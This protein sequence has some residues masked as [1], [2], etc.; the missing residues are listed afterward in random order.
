MLAS[1]RH[2]QSWPGPLLAVLLLLAAPSAG[3][4]DFGAAAQQDYRM[5]LHSLERTVKAQAGRE[6]P[7]PPALYPFGTRPPAGEESQVWRHL[8]I[9]RALGRLEGDREALERVRGGT[10]FQ[11]VSLARS[12]WNLSEYDSSLVWY[13]RAARRDTTAA[14]HEDI[15]RESLAAAIALGDSLLITQMLLNTIGTSRL[16]GRE[17]ELALAY[18][19][20]LAERNTHELELLVSK[21]A[22]NEDRMGPRLR[23][24]HAFA[25]TSLGRWDRALDQLQRLLAGGGLSHGLG[26]LQR[27]WV[28][29]TVPDL[30]FLLGRGA[31][32]RPLY[33]QLTESELPELQGWAAYQLGNLDFL[34][35]KYD[36]ARLAYVRLCGSEE[37]GAWRERA[38]AMAELAELLAA[39]KTEGEAY[40]RA[41]SYRP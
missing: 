26:R 10:A 35:M 37:T 1:R 12:Y 31:E 39:I 41:A 29:T 21:L 3:A 27:C 18:R 16:E 4:G 8:S 38:C 11:A 24:W 17:E 22:R 28:L 23:Y 6:T 40:G 30:L 2:P 32:A 9:G 36:R 33:A 34:A 20:L 14:Y 5:W 7:E 19:Y 25:L 15:G 13:E